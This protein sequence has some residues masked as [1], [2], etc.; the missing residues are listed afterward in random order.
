NSVHRRDQTRRSESELPALHCPFLFTPAGL[1]TVHSNHR[2]R[3]GGQK[4][5]NYLILT[6]PGLKMVHSRR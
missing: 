4:R 2:T 5:K 6:T 1:K 3:P